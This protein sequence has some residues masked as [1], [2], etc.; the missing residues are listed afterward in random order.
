MPKSSAQPTYLNLEVCTL[1]LKT[2]IKYVPEVPN[3]QMNE[4]KKN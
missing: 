3:V 4:I 1:A 2:S